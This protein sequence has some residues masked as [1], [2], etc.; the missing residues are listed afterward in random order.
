[1][2]RWLV[3][4]G[5]IGAVGA[6]AYMWWNGGA[7]EAWPGPDAGA[8]G[9]AAPAG[10][11]GAPVRAAA[12]GGGLPEA[13]AAEPADAQPPQGEAADPAL[14]QPGPRQPVATPL[15]VVPD[16]RLTAID[17]QSVPSLRDG[18]ILFI[19]TEAPA[20]GTMPTDRANDYFEE[21]ITQLLVE[22]SSAAGL[23]PADIY[24]VP[25]DTE[26][27]K[28]RIFSP[29]RKG[30]ELKPHKV[31]VRSRKLRFRRLRDGDPVR[32]EQLL[33]IVD[34]SLAL[35]DLDIKL[36]KLD[37]AEADA[38]ASARTRDETWQRWLTADRLYAKKVTPE[39][40]WRGAKLTYERYR[41]ETIAK[42]EQVKV[43]AEELR[44]S[45]TV[46][47]QH[48][49][50]ADISG[51]VK[52]ILKHRGDSVRNLDTLMVLQDNRRLRIEG[53]VD[54][55][56]RR[57]LKPGDRVIV[58]PTQSVSPDHVL[59]G[60]M[61]DITGVAVTQKGE[62][63]SASED[64]TVRVWQTQ[65]EQERLILKHFS[66]V[67]A[68][69]A[70][71]VANRV[72]SGANDGVG[73]IWDLDSG[74]TAPVVE[75][76]GGHKGAVNCVAWSPDGKWCATGGEDRNIVIWDAESGQVVAQL[77]VQQGHRGGVTS[78]QFIP[79]PA[80][81]QLYLVSV[82][83]G[84]NTMLAWQLG[85]DAKAVGAPRNLGRRGGDVTVLGFD[86]R[87]RQALFDQGKELR[88]LSIPDGTLA[89]VISAGGSANFTTMA[90]FSPTG[91]M[92]LTASGND[93]RLQLWR[94]PTPRTRGY[95][96][97]QFAGPG[98]AATC[99]AF[100]P[101]SRFAVTGTRDRAVMVWPLPKP[102][103]LETQ[104]TAEVTLVENE[105]DL[106]SRQVRVH[107]EI[108]NH[109]FEITADTLRTLK[110]NGLSDAAVERLRPLVGKEFASDKE[111][112]KALLTAFLPQDLEGL[113]EKI[114]RFA[115]KAGP[116]LP[117]NSVN[118]VVYPRTEGAAGPAVKPAP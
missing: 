43:A 84:D 1:M 67:R 99:G 12:A 9:P 42:E 14:A 88:I 83:R 28:G 33:A 72:L 103:E 3:I 86:P 6:G 56:Y 7:P 30:D 18:K 53:R 116:L 8:A 90:L 19:G 55:Q 21:T 80:E 16:A 60:H 50:R 101:Q 96:V 22:R 114:Y 41:Y 73:R 76:K 66:P 74:K 57:H 87:G 77:P 110:A 48:F 4:F 25:P 54:Y 89:G 59:V 85:A 17:V 78:V 2:V 36:R 105:L 108:D 61:A 20:D 117:G 98:D 100:D 106:N 69:A 95:E 11:A 82:G 115:E 23:D 37:A 91:S 111:F 27:G 51:R 49:V 58:E 68:V 63:V 71:P 32:A 52:N 26:G 5:L 79:G 64:Q 94:T 102:Q 47:D 104:F 31:L 39:E 13:R 10:P 118:L 62:V 107:A 92:I 109:W 97:R 81:G 75:L 24:P 15:V 29:M 46:L 70:S 40:D 113:R 65:P 38:I 44:Q 93:G 34:P 35:A 45:A 112:E